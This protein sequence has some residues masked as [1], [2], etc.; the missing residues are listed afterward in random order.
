MLVR[1]GDRAVAEVVTDAVDVFEGRRI[2]RRFDEIEVELVDGDA[3]EM[4]AIVRRLQRAG[5]AESDS[6]PKLFQALDLPA[7]RPPPRPRRR[8][9]G[10]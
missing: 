6:R 1:D 10:R 7:V 3:A 5:A 9:A 8:R 4:R 2:M